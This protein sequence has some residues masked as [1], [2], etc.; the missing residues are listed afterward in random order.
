MAGARIEITVDSVGPALARAAEQL[1]GDG[2]RLML[3]D[4][5]EYLLRSTRERS[6]REVAPDGTPWPALQPAYQRRKEKRKPGKAMLHFDE[7]MLGDQLSWQVLGETLYVGT[8]AVYGAVHHF[9]LR[10]WLGLSDDD[11]EKVEEI[12]FA[13]I[14]GMFGD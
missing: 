2:L 4:I 7:H 9:G 13:R 1:G 10:P 8:N 14:A 3:E 12:S 11:H 6:L 5:G